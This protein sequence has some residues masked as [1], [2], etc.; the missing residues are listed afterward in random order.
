MNSAELQLGDKDNA[1]TNGVLTQKIFSRNSIYPFLNDVTCLDF[2]LCS[3]WLCNLKIS[4]LIYIYRDN[5]Y[6]VNRMPSPLRRGLHHI[7][8]FV[9]FSENTL[10]NSWHYRKLFSIE[11]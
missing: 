10:P 4:T 2:S 1:L 8:I 11:L 3:E 5:S 7:L 9:F 6:P